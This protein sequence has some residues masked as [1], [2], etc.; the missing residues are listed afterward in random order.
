MKSLILIMWLFPISLV[1]QAQSSATLPGDSTMALYHSYSQLKEQVNRLQ[2]QQNILRQQIGEI[3]DLNRLRIDSL[4]NLLEE[5]DNE[6]AALHDRTDSFSDTLATYHNAY[7][8]QTRAVLRDYNN[9]KTNGMIVYIFTILLIAGIFIY[10]F[11]MG[12]RLEKTFLHRLQN[13]GL[14]TDRR[15]KKLSGKWKTRF[16]KMK[17]ISRKKGKHK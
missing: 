10:I 9:M 2:T 15:I 3:D 8:L 12:N 7:L 14:E 4:Q 17:K 13:Y 16:T 11:Y 1:S 5:K 6:I